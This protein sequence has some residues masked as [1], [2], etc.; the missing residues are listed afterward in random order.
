MVVNHSQDSKTKFFKFLTTVHHDLIWSKSYFHSHPSLLETCCSLSVVPHFSLTNAR[1]SAEVPMAFW[2]FLIS[3]P[4]RETTRF[5]PL[6]LM[7]LVWSQKSKSLE[8]SRVYQESQETCFHHSLTLL[9]PLLALALHGA[10]TRLQTE[11]MPKPWATFSA[12]V[13]FSSFISWPFNVRHTADLN[14]FLLSC[15]QLF[16]SLLLFGHLCL[17]QARHVYL[18]SISI[19]TSLPLPVDS[20]SQPWNHLSWLRTC[21]A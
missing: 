18:P 12:I 10:L 16:I 3:K 19:Q 1:N 2:I 6:R 14:F 15:H 8:M 20:S 13:H 9:N 5:H 11:D 7:E 4:R 17:C 21:L